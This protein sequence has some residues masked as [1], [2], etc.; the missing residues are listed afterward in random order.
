M[1]TKLMRR[2]A[3][4]AVLLSGSS[5]VTAG[6][7]S[8]VIGD[9]PG[10]G[11]EAYFGEDAAYTENA[12]ND[13]AD[14]DQNYADEAYEADVAPVAHREYRTVSRPQVRQR[15]V[16][17]KT[18]AP[19][20]GRQL[21]PVSHH[22]SMSCDCGTASC[23]G[24]CG[25]MEISC[26]IEESCGCGASS[27]DGGCGSSF[28]SSCGTSRR[29]T[30][31]F[32]KGNSNTWATMEF[33]LWFGQDRDSPSL[34]TTSD[35]GTLPS[36]PNDLDIATNVDNVNTVFGNDFKGELTPGFRADMGIWL[37]ENVGVG[38]RFWI[39][40]E[41]EDSYGF[42]GNGDNMSVGRSFFNND[43]GTE[44]AVVIAA[45][46]APVGPDVA[47]T[48]IGEDS[49]DI[50][51]AEAYAR[52]RFGCSKSCSLDFIGGYSHFDIDNS[53]NIRSTSEI[54]AN[55]D[56]GTAIGDRLTFAD[57]FE[58][59][60]EFNGGQLGFDMTMKR[61]RWIASSLT[62]VHLGN[63]NQRLSVRGS[64]IINGVEDAGGI[65][66]GSTPIDGSRD[67]FAFAPE[68]NFKLAY[69]FRPNVA[70]SVGYSFIYFDN[71]AL[72]GDVIDRNVNGNDIGSG[73]NNNGVQI[74]DSSLFVQGVDLGFTID[75]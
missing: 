61:G 47:G 64:S 55:P 60:N 30:N 9:L 70:L 19:I 24:G 54:T 48:I 17:Q 42:T 2:L 13:E 36:L 28:G 23:D 7:G 56:P 53:L 21:Q 73:A 33:L 50:W 74:D 75:F 39:L 32:N 16:S 6:D 59:M 27:C 35:A 43:F 12:Y 66:A 14:F 71:V 26:G 40:N 22:S 8:S 58:T 45:T 34:I 31:L 44:D 20:D 68:A 52:L 72:T 41:S 63:M 38:G 5:M 10:Y 37:S 15:V 11:E 4:A 49:L 51:A 69:K 62:K 57:R 18:Y 65:L 3:I 46:G 1:K 29:M 25:S 67:V